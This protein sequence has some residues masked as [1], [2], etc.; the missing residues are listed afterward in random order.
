MRN[1]RSFIA[2]LLV[3]IL[4]VFAFNTAEAQNGGEQHFP[5]NYVVTGEFLK[6]YLSAPDPQLLFGNA[7]SNVMIEAGTP[8]QYF[9]RARFELKETEKGPQVELATLGSF[10][11]PT[12]SEESPASATCRYFPKTGHRVC[13]DLLQFYNEYDG[14]KYFGNPESEMISER[15][16]LVQY[17]EYARFEYHFNMAPGLKVGL[18]NIGQLAMKKRYSTAPQTSPDI[19]FGKLREVTDIQ[20]RAYVSRALVS[21]GS[22]NTL[23]VVVHLPDFTGVAQANVNVSVQIGDQTTDLAVQETDE[24]GIAK[25]EIPAYDLKPR[26]TVQL[27][28][29]VN[30]GEQTVKTSTWY[31]FWY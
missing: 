19:I 1:W 31:R 5:G 25:I 12:D 8:V 20:A 27:I 10:L 7:I 26:E 14:P 15:G 16:Q 6:F 21:P 22:T 17:F 18:T 9:D 28:V 24:D 13:F 4:V 30:Y 29:E 3:L 2:F 23:Y 11:S